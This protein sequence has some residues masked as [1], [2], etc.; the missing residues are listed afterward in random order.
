[1]GILSTLGNLGVGPAIKAEYAPQV[2]YNEQFQLSPAI[3][4]IDRKAAMSIPAAAKARSL[5]VNNVSSTPLCLYR[6][7][8]GEELGKPVWLKQPCANQPA[9]ITY[10]QTVDSLIWYGTAYWRITEQY[11]D[12]GRPARFEYIENRRVTWDLDILNTTITKY[13][14]DGKPVPMW[15]LGSLITFQMTHEGVLNYGAEV[16][17]QALNIEKAASVNAAT[18]MP[19]GILKNNG[20][21]L[22]EQEV[23]GLLAKW[24]QARQQKSVAYLTQALEFIPTQFSNRDNQMVESQANMATQIAR[25]MNVPAY[26]LSADQNTSM[27][28]SNLSDENKFFL[29]Q[30]LQTYYSAIEQRLSMD[31]ITRIGNMVKFDLD[32]SILRP[33]PMQRLAVTEKM[34]QLGLIDIPTAQDMNDITPT[35]TGGISG[36]TDI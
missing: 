7:S 31:D 17:L 21:D 24:K 9:V 28:Y 2:L 11:A 10:A 1:M 18:P 35:P 32:D 27:T 19:A 8:T 13:Y 20:A 12:D 14:V 16:L 34:L 36:P 4:R 33:D 15:G 22:P 3:Q 25:L 5:I 29:Q 30:T 6:E 26:Y 23:Q